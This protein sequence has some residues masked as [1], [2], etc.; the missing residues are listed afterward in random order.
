MIW[1][2]ASSLAVKIDVIIQPKSSRDE[3]VGMHGD[4]LKIKLTAPPVDGKANAALITFLAK[5]LGIPKSNITIIRGKTGRR[6][7]IE[8][9]DVSH[10]TIAKA[11]EQN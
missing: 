2:G 9:C 7:T 5:T 11:I 1:E 3:I 8:L 10:K 4:C 6:K